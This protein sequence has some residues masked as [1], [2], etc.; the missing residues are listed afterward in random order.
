MAEIQK[1][2]PIRLSQATHD[3]RNRSMAGEFGKQLTENYCAIIDVP[4]Y[5]A[6]SDY[7][8]YTVALEAVV[9]QCPIRL[10]DGEWLAGSA[11]F[12]RA[13][14]NKFP[15]MIEGQEKWQNFWGK[16]D[17]LTPHHQKIITK[18]LR[19]LD[20]QIR[21]SKEAYKNLPQKVHY[22]EQL[23]KT[24]E[25]IRRWHRRYMDAIDERIA[26]TEGEVKARW[27]TVRQNLCRVPE[28]PA[29]NF[30]EAIQSLWFM[31]AFLRLNANWAAV[32][33]IDWM[34]GPYLKKDL[35]EGTITLDEAREYVAH[36][37]IKGCEW[38]DLL[39]PAGF[40][41][42]DGDGQFYQNVVLSGQD[43]Q[44]NDE[45]NEV[46]Y[47]V[48]DVLEELRIA[49][50]PTSVRLSTKSDEKLVR[51][52]AEVTRLGGGL[53]AIYN[54][55]VVIEALVR[56]GYPREE[57]CRYA[58]DG[59]W[60]VQIPGKTRFSYKPWDV[61]AELHQNVLFLDQEGPSALPYESFDQ[62]F[63]AYVEQLR[64][65]FR[66]YREARILW[67]P[68][69]PN[70]LMSLLVE[71]CIYK[72]R[73]FVDYGAAYDVRSPHA[74]GIVDAANALQAIKHVVYDE[75]MMSLNEFMDILKADWEGHEELRLQLRR[76]LTYYGN[77]DKAGDA[78]MQKVFDAYTEVIGERKFY[79]GILYPAGISTFGRQVIPSF[80]DRRSANADG[81]KKGDILSN[82]MSPTPGSD[83]RGATAT[84]RSYGSLDMMKLPGG[85]ALEVKMS[86]A[87]V[88][89]DDGL[90]GLVDLLY[91]FC[92]LGCHFAQLDVVDAAMLKKAYEDPETYGNLVVRVSGW[93][94]R[95][96]TMGRKWQQMVMERT[97]MGY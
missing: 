65:I 70:L 83:I 91:S 54:D 10:V 20:E 66:E 67:K 74:G 1:T 27:Q 26:N 34:L 17:H 29:A 76:G 43:A 14:E 19:G 47:L 6:L 25:Q 56:F 7:E 31:L 60:E 90:E 41:D 62:L 5:E 23:E 93:S 78:M 72:A 9:T 30:R 97:E 44:G 96:K 80:L 2:S 18:G 82:N 85:T 88:R 35:E 8:K 68:L 11:T 57:A 61:L 48:L 4:N 3:L 50:F 71:N 28:E 69:R 79:N 39:P 59:C 92:E 38:V 15:A 77:G 87:T 58:N 52:V 22:L 16:N 36:F 84:F 33:R 95:F 81:H 24:V 89:G 42:G 12:D 45:T 40:P 64:T 63:D 49:D 55:D 53:I 51:R 32:G 21:E 37:W 13:R 75:K 94:A 86:Y 73:D 46:T